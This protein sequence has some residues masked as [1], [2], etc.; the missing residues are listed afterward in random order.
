MTKSE[1][2]PPDWSVIVGELV[3]DL[4]SALDHL[5]WQLVLANGETP[6]ETS[7]F[8][9]Y[10]YGRLGRAKDRKRRAAQW[11][12][13]LYGVDPADARFIKALQPYR[14]RHRLN[15]VPLEEVATFSNIDKH[16]LLLKAALMAHP[17]PEIGPFITAIRPAPGALVVETSL[18][19]PG[20][21]SIDQ[22]VVFQF[23]VEP[24]GAKVEVDMND[25]I[26]VTVTLGEASAIPFDNLLDLIE[27]VERIVEYFA[28][29]FA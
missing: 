23:R 8:P 22:T 5:V 15:F 19:S 17:D 6:R 10:S 11:R 12:D 26:P 21:V 24:P 25:N 14:R 3:H 16:R 18:S 28:P 4:R 29:R 27:E 13:R 2:P 9:I 20:L 7:Q 1:P